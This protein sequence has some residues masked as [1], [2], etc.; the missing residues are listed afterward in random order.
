MGLGV[1]W[2]LVYV[3]VNLTS[4]MYLGA[5]SLNTL[6]GMPIVYGVLALAIFS[7]IYTIYGGLTAVAWTDFIQVAVLFLGGIMVTYLG[8][9]AVGGEG[10]S[11]VD[12]W[13]RLLATA[14]DR[15]HT[16][17]P[18]HH[19][20]LPWIGVF[21]GGMWIANLS[22]WGFNQY[23]TQR[24]L[25]G[26]DLTQARL[27]LAFA[28]LLK[29]L[30]PIVLVVP[31]VIAFVLFADQIERPDMAYPTLIRDIVPPGWTGLV[32]AAL[33]AAIVSSLNSMANSAA[34]I[35]TMDIARPLLKI[36]S[37]RWL[38]RTG[39]IATG[40]FLVIAVLMAPGLARFDQVFQYIQEYTGMV[41]PGVCVIFFLGLLWSRATSAA[42]LTVAILTI[43]VGAGLK[44]LP[45]ALVPASM[46]TKTYVPEGPLTA[47][48]AVALFVNPFLNRM[49]L[50][51]LILLGLGIAV[52]LMTRHAP[53]E[54]QEQA[55]GRGISYRTSALFNV[56]AILLLGLLAALYYRFW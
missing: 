13:N 39:R 18:W 43:P 53:T 36:E 20:D 44:F 2:L 25:A 30:V 6:L 23:I 47:P 4:V 16:A 14:P 34:T 46:L 17:L 22:Y 3:F 11:V 8:L 28:A 55:V 51:F 12:G 26:R 5:L 21:F 41:S 24:A 29:I 19:N 48:E 52:S 35:F 49:G 37:E 31:G 27:G 50:A 7:A 38:V 15:F 1:F 42:A 10:A 40:T 45:Y 33:I 54:A 9:Q 56:A 32:L